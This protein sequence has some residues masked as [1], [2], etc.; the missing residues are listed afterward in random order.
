MYVKIPFGL[1][2]VGATF[3]CVVDVAFADIIDKFLV[4]Y[5]LEIFKTW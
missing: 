3:Q 5:L 4:V 2:N 1:T